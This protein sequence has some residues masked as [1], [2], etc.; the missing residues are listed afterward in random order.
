MRVMK[1]RMSRARDAFKLAC[2]VLFDDEYPTHKVRGDVFIKMHD[3]SSGRV[4]YEWERKNL[5]VYDQK[6]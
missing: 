6:S 2:G 1:D 5:I 4:L 3:A